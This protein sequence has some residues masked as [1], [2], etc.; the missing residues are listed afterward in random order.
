MKPRICVSL[1]PKTVAEAHNLIEKAEKIGPDFI[2]LRLDHLEPTIN[3]SE[4]SNLGNTPKIATIQ[5]TL[6][7]GSFALSKLNQHKFLIKAA[8]NDFEYVDIAL[9]SPYLK[10]TVK[11]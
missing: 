5:S 11:K 10:E 3:L 6:K 9:D 8:K 2:E 4:L 1:L 7:E